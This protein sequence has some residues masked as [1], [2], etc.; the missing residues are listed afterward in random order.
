MVKKGRWEY[1]TRNTGRPSVTIVAVTDDREILLVEQYRIPL[2]SN[3]IE[4]PAGMVGD[5]VG[6]EDEPMLHAAKRELLEETGYQADSWSQIT[7]GYSSPGLT[8]ESTNVFLARGLE[9]IGA[10]GGVDT[11]DILVHHVP[12]DNLMVWVTDRKLPYDLKML[13]AVYAVLPLLCE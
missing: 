7:H 10:G 4:L 5:I 1:A 9:K 12:L 8:D 11:E 13:G 6:E 3:V 2:E